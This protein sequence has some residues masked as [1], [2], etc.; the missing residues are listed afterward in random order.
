MKDLLLAAAAFA[1]LAVA[2]AFAGTDRS[3]DILVMNGCETKPV[4]SRDGTRVLYRNAVDPTCAGIAASPTNGP[5]PVAE[6]EDP[7]K[8]E[9]CPEDVAEAH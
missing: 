2:P 8:G 7:G 6:E 5:R 1:V 3:F 4:L 9:D